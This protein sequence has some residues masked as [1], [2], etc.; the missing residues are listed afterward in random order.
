MLPS[1]FDVCHALDD[2][3]DDVDVAFDFDAV[4]LVGT[5][6]YSNHLGVDGAA[7]GAVA[8]RSMH[9]DDSLQHSYC[10]LI[11]RNACDHI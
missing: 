6:P 2:G 5:A 1:F 8:P 11:E 4:A 7:G 9:F 10:T 3:R